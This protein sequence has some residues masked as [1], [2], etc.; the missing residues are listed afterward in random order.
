MTR[1][2]CSRAG[3]ALSNLKRWRQARN[4]RPVIGSNRRPVAVVVLALTQL[5]NV[6]LVPYLAHAGLALAIG[7]GAMVNALWL[8]IGLIRRGAYTPS[9]GWARF[10]LQVLA[11]SALLAVYLMWLAARVDW[12][13][14][15]AHAFQRVGLL[16]LSVLGAALIYFISLT[17]AGV[18][19]RQ[20]VRK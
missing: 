16:A 20:F 7:L 11:A 8:L 12:V 4:V 14:L 2:P 9:A 13:A 10:S 5:M 1:S 17:L 19:L 18:K 15:Q 3:R 6:V